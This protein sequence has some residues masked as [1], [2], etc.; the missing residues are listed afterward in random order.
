VLIL[1]EPPPEFFL[2]QPTEGEQLTVQQDAG[3]EGDVVTH[4]EFAAPGAGE[5]DVLN[6]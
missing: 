1:C 3:R 2:G 6:P 5:L 4:G